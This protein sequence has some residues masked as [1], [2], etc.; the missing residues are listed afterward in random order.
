MAQTAVAGRNKTRGS[1]HHIN[2]TFLLWEKEDIST[3]A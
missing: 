1:G 2:R 3:V